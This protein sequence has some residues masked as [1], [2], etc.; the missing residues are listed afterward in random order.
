MSRAAFRLSRLAVPSAVV[1][2][3][4]AELPGRST[5]SARSPIRSAASS[6]AHIQRRKLSRLRPLRVRVRRVRFSVRCSVFGLQPMRPTPQRHGERAHA[7]ER[8]SRNEKSGYASPLQP[9]TPQRGLQQPQ[10]FR[11][12]ASQQSSAFASASFWARVM[13]VRRGLDSFSRL[14][15]KGGSRF[16]SSS[17]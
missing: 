2:F 5:C 10:R 17:D 9:S 1:A 14:S 16:S 8:E 3:S 7:S 13:A 12:S 6:S 11:S 15:S 4:S